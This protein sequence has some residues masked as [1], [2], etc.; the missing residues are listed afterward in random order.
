[1]RLPALQGPQGRLDLLDRQALTECLT[2]KVPRK[3][4]PASV[5]SLHML[6]VG[7][8]RVL[9][10]PVHSV[11]CQDS[12]LLRRT[13][14]KVRNFRPWDPAPGATTRTR[15]DL[16]VTLEYLQALAKLAA[17]PPTILRTTKPRLRV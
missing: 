12:T 11:A 5:T 15:L 16:A 10:D 14:R 17:S 2:N 13:S 3:V 9:L 7:V 8:V 4:V 6:A 1:M